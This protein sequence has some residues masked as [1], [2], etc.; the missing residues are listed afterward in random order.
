MRTKLDLT[1]AL[2]EELLFAMEDQ[3]NP[4]V[5]DIE[6]RA[7][8]EISEAAD[9]VDD[10]TRY[11]PLPRWSSQDGFRMMAW[12]VDTVKNPLLQEELRMILDSG[13][14]VFRRFKSSLKQRPSILKSWQDFKRR[15]MQKAVTEWI[16]EWEDYWNLASLD[17]MPAEETETLVDT[18]FDFDEG[19]K[20]RERIVAAWDELAHEEVA[21]G[22][23]WPESGRLLQAFARR[24]HA[25]AAEDL[26]FWG[27]A[28]DEEAGLLWV[29]PW[30]LV[31]GCVWE[32]LLWYVSPPYRGL[33]LGKALFNR[34]HER[35]RETGAT[36]MILEIWGD[37]EA[38]ERVVRRQGFLPSSRRFHRN[39]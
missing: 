23:G 31:Y 25:A 34:A 39:F 6:H 11:I 37:Q 32:V 16:R 8:V 22:A 28:P 2:L 13:Q 21:S 38:L 15:T 19:L 20:G 14:G 3:D 36:D 26:F 33:G 35:A 29:R 5:M 1:E 27:L 7:L 24:S 17:L 30:K 18:D 4:R 12:F 9:D 10:P